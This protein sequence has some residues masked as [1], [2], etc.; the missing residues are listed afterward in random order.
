MYRTYC[1]LGLTAVLVACGPAP[2]TEPEPPI[3]TAA[4][5]EAKEE[6]RR[7]SIDD[8]PEKARPY[9]RYYR[10]HR[11]PSRNMALAEQECSW[12]H[13]A[14]S[15]VG[16]LGC[17]QVMPDTLKWGAETFAAHLGDPDP[18]NPEYAAHFTEA[19][20]VYF[21]IEEFDSYCPNRAVD[22]LRYNGGYYILWELR[23]SDGTFAGAE[24]I[25]GT[26]LPNGRKRSKASCDQ[27]YAYHRH[28]DRRQPK[29]RAMGGTICNSE[30]YL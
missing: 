18:H 11:N 15:P 24:A 7:R 30:D 12:N 26:R 25:C 2:V 29:Y 5:F 16:A 14:V 23:A 13:F 21:D 27:N 1:I 22:E 28:I 20:M 17:A 19:Y 9:A 8:I 6:P 3:A 10:D 4:D